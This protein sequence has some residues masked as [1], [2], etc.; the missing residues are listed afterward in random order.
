MKDKVEPRSPD[1][2]AVS[3]VQYDSVA[4]ELARAAAHAR[5]LEEKLSLTRAELRQAESSV[6]KAQRRMALLEYRVE[7]REWQLSVLRSRR[8]MSVGR[9]LSAARKSPA[10][11]L[12]LPWAIAKALQ[13]PVAV[14]PRPEPPGST[15]ERRGV[16]ERDDVVQSLPVEPA[17]PVPVL[18][19]VD[20]DTF[21]AL[22][23]EL[24]LFRLDW[25]TW[26]RQL[27]DLA[28]AMLLVDAVV[29]AAET[30]GHLPD[31][32]EVC[33]GQGIRTILWVEGNSGGPTS[34]LGFDS[35]FEAPLTLFQPRL[36]NPIGGQRRR[37]G[38]GVIDVAGL[39]IDAEKFPDLHAL[40][41]AAHRYHAVIAVAGPPEVD[42]G[43]VL[44]TAT[45][46]LVSGNDD[47]S[48]LTVRSQTEA[49]SASRALARSEVL[50]ARLTHPQ[51]R[52]A[53][54]GARAGV[55]ARLLSQGLPGSV[56]TGEQPPIDV[57]VATNRPQN[58]RIVFD[59]LSRQ[60]YPQL[61]LVLVEHGVRLDRG[62][63]NDRA[64]AAGFKVDIVSVGEEVILGEVF[65]IGFGATVAD[66]VAKMDDDDFYGPEY[67]WDLRSALGFSGAD[68]VGKWAHYVYLKGIDSTIYRFSHYEH[69]FTD[70]VAISTLLMKRSVFELA[71]FP[72]LAYGS[73]SIFLREIGAAGA[74]VYAAD[75]WN[76]LY[77]RGQDGERNTF[78]AADFDLVANSQVVCRG[79]NYDEVVV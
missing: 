71:R 74:V 27:E 23:H 49:D 47:G 50:R 45:P 25:D 16:G 21:A 13:E 41:R 1:E 59:N 57:M 43:P 4:H 39:T 34:S 5:A 6:A 37:S 54:R 70:V 61:R 15:A 76:Y 72:Q 20:D 12:A 75:R 18:A 66:V 60:T 31:L 3:R 11:L 42:L 79:I 38:V 22:A 32:L 9:A 24:L 33:A 46:V 29:A 14:H 64:E 77:I 7:L 55:V 26:E 58:L 48:G 68:V 52:G 17:N 19:A 63:V 8:W 2:S 67:L 56:M 35:V 44:A 36:H 51:V 53:L 78:P 69:R 40:T 62:E 10:K 28:P 73:G 65:N 30:E